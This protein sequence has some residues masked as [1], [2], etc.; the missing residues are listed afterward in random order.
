VGLRQR[1][2]QALAS[3]KGTN[4]IAV[5]A[6]RSQIGGLF[7]QP[8][9]SLP[10]DAVN[11][12]EV[13]RT[14]PT[15]GRGIAVIAEDAASVP[16]KLVRVSVD[17]KTHEDVS[18]SHPAVRLFK[19]INAVDTP[20]NYWISVY[21]D[22][23][24][25]GN[26]YSHMEFDK[27]TEEPLTLYRLPSHQ[28][29]PKPDQKKIVRGYWWETSD[30]IVQKYG[31]REILHFKTPNIWDP[32]VGMSP[33][34]RLRGSIVLERQM[35]R[36]NYNRFI[37]DISA[38]LIFFTETDFLTEE[39]LDKAKEYIKTRFSGV[40]KTRD[41]LI[42][43][44]DKWDIKVLERP[45]DDDI[46]FLNGLK[47]L[48]AEAAMVLGVPPSKLSDY[49]DSFRSNS[50]EMDLTYWEDTIMSWHKL[51]LD[52]FN[53]IFLPRF[54]GGQQRLR[55]MYDYSGI[56]ALAIS[57][58]DQAQVQEILTRS[59][60]VSANEARQVLGYDERPEKEADMLLHNGQPLGKAPN[61]GSVAKPKPAGPSDTDPE[62]DGKR[63]DLSWVD[64]AMKELNK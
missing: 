14:N 6:R 30:G 64:C 1:F 58:F 56:A 15:I 12:A 48:R 10:I 26:H 59:G 34:D 11:L 25:I 37:N 50:K 22:L 57:E 13:E 40:E 27:P 32:Y 36:W 63:F 39:K 53:T 60:V 24:T 17:G 23:L 42:L 38:G 3:L 52:V 61:P 4:P 44:G 41:P 33:L 35:R 18:D 2:S 62:E 19:H 7:T 46:Q 54:Y 9:A 43:A 16:L 5:D 49:S 8:M 51:V 47:W 28:V 21:K 20:S 29:K 31:L 45:S 55:F